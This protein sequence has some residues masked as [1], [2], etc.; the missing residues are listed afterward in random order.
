VS[1][2]DAAAWLEA[3]LADPDHTEADELVEACTDTRCWLRNE[4]R[5]CHPNDCS[6]PKMRRRFHPSAE[7]T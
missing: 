2:P 3:N 1:N 6:S 5:C 7:A 4:G